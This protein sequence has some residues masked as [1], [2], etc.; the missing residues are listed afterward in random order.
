[1]RRTPLVVLCLLA[2][3]CQPESPREAAKPAMEST[4]SETNLASSELEKSSRIRFEDE[5]SEP[6]SRSSDVAPIR[7]KLT[8]GKADSK[9]APRY[10]PP[11][12]GLKLEPFD[13]PAE[14]GVDGLLAEVVLGAPIEKQTP[15]KLLVTRTNLEALYTKLYV[16]LDGNGKFDEPAVEATMSDSRGMTWSNFNATLKAK[17]LGEET[18]TEDYPVV[19]WLTVPAATDRPDV[20][21]ISRRGYKFGEMSLGEETLSIVLSDSNNDAVFGE[22]DW[23]EL[24]SSDQP[25][26]SNDMRRVGD[27]A[28]LGKTAYKLEVDSPFAGSVRLYPFDPGITREADELARDPYGADKTAVKAEKPLEFRHDVDAALAEAADKKLPCFIKFETTWCGP[29]KM[30]TQLVFTAKEVVDASNGV[31]C[32]MVDGDERKDLVERYEVKAYPTGVMIAADGTE[33]ARFVGYQKV[34]E[35]AAFL[36]DKR[37]TK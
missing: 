6:K 1:M 8:A 31:M 22:G 28:W 17:Y 23:W 21:R 11:G 16:D 33:A 18:V 10:S 2:A 15:I 24:R 34:T 9:L 27:F 3:G 20:I 19:F 14:L 29:C 12:K 37:E 4:I 25:T 13:T 32:V 5:P 30:M 35:M 26:N 7:M 36:K